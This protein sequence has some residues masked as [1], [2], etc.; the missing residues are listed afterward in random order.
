MGLFRAWFLDPLALLFLLSLVCI[1]ML[2][3]RKFGFVR[4]LM[5]L[6]WIACFLMVS[7]PRIVN[8]MV[9]HYESQYSD[10]PNCLVDNPIVILGAGLRAGVDSAESLEFM[11]QSTF[12]RTA[13]GLKL[14]NAFPKQRVILAGG[15]IRSISEAAVMAEFL[16]AAG[17]DESRLIIEGGSMNTAE[18][19]AKVRDILYQKEMPETINLVTSALHMK[20]AEAVFKKL[21]VNVCPVASDRIA[22]SRV[23]KIAWMP[24]LS[25]LDK[26]DKLMHE[27][28][29]MQVYKLRGK[30]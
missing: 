29:A 20:R 11:K 4:L 17:V 25:A 14:V 8:P 30:I 12:A 3:R 18:N 6:F 19:G 5:S 13:R 1:F 7:A 16:T 24:Q 22:A 9:V 23:H 27:F 28:I 21:G 10:A 26:F 15:G 2:L